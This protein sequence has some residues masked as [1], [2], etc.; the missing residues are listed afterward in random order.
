MDKEDSH[1]ET[2]LE[3]CE[4]DSANVNVEIWQ[5]YYTDVEDESRGLLPFRVWQIYDEMVQ[6]VRSGKLENFVC[7]AGILSHYVG[8]ACQPLHIS[9]MFNGDPADSESVERRNRYTGKTEVIDQPRAAGVHSTY[10]EKMVNYHVT[11]IIA[12]LGE[13]QGSSK[14]RIKGGK[15]AAVAV[16]EL[17]QQTFEA[18]KPKEIVDE[19]MRHKDA[20]ETPKPIADALWS[21]FGDKTIAI[22][23][24]G[25]ECL[26]MLWESAWL[27]GSGKKSSD[28][29]EKAFGEEK[30]AAIYQNK[31]FLISRTLNNIASLL[32]K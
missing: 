24:E 16:V 22:M 20:G 14:K 4:A 10:E 26:A 3:L 5:S 1:G 2:L 27:E 7:A 19:Y 31:A 17:M 12:G 28:G 30:L 8:D 6:C 11:E 18:I 9:Y 29:S 32:D 15:G 13:N 25:C 21:K 23:S